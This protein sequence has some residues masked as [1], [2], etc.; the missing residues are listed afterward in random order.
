MSYKPKKSAFTLA[1]LMVIMAVM[2]VVLAAIAPIFT[3]RFSNFSVD[4]VWGN[5]GAS[6]MNDIY[7][8][9]PIRPMMEQLLI[10]ITPVDMEDVRRTYQPYSKVIIRS[11]HKVNGNKLQKQIEFRQNGTNVGYLFAGN[12]N[13]LFGG[14]YPNLSFTY[15]QPDLDNITAMNIGEGASGNTALGTDTLNA[16]TTGKNNSAFGYYALNNITTGNGNTA[17]G[18]KAGESLTTAEG[19]TL[20]GYHSYDANSG[21]Y[22]TI[23]SNNTSS[24]STASNYTTAVGN[25]INV[26]GDHNVAIGDSSNAGG[27]FNTAVGYGA[28]QSASPTSDS[29]T[30]FKYNTAIG[31]NACKGISSSAQGTTCIGGSG[32][33]TSSMSAT[34]QNFFNDTK[35]RVLI[36]RSA[37]AFNS[38]ATLEV[39]NLITSGS[40]Y[41]YPNNISGAP[42]L[43]DS[44]VIVNGNLIVRGQTYMA[45]R[46]PFPMAPSA[47]TSTYANTISLM[48]Y[49]LYKESTLDH[50]PLIGL[51]GSEH[52]QRI[53]NADNYMR[54]AYTGREHCLCNY[55]C[56]NSSKDYA[57]GLGYAGRD[58]YDWSYLAFKNYTN[59]IDNSFGGYNYFWGHSPH[60][61]GSGYNDTAYSSA[62]IELDRGHNMT[63]GGNNSVATQL[64]SGGSCCPI[65]TPLGIRRTDDLDALEVQTSDIRLKNVGTPFEKGLK[66][67][68]KLHIYN[69]TFKN[70]NSDKSHVGVIAQD[71]KRIFPTAVSKDSKGYYKIR[72]DEMFYS[73]INSVKEL[74]IKLAEL[75]SRVQK[76]VSRL[77]ALKNE[78]K[79]LKQKL[80]MLSKELDELEK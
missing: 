63:D 70:D 36:G 11:S 27:S 48:G 5:V 53:K 13:L 6:N 20:I 61:C 56:S 46:S 76:D 52:T 66:F 23:I 49:K 72:R 9:A 69:F 12:S 62:N 65:L 58:S 75:A 77:L 55:S 3:S 42:V 39:H 32:I 14:K 31:Y 19:N 29:Y 10:G 4:S 34:A 71:L 15:V 74:Y 1:E 2:T 41:P 68:S 22:N 47:S 78:N 79:M 73:A 24:K 64:I 57:N 28:L 40:K 35:D 17:V 38:A 16:L 25:N 33:D 51:D 43:G 59:I 60:K 7:A 54:E 26:K 45:G 18:V 8:D 67:L 30:N 44:S 50:K 80:I 37:S 21:N